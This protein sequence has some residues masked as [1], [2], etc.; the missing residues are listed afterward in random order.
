[1]S[2][3]TPGTR[4][5][6]TRTSGTRTSGSRTSG[7]QTSSRTRSRASSGRKLRAVEVEVVQVGPKPEHL[8]LGATGLLCL[9]GIVMVYSASSVASVQAS[10]ANWS[11]GV[12]QLVWM[13]LGLALGLV[14]SRIPLMFWRDRIAPV[15]IL[16]AL[17]LQAIL[18]LDIALGAVGGPHIPFAL[19]KNGATRW[20]G[21]D[22]FQVQPSDFAKLALILWLARLL[23]K[24][25]R[26]IGSRE[27]LKPIF[28]VTG[29]LSLMVLLGD[30]LGTTLLLGVIVIVMLFLA[31]A[32]LRQVGV[33]AG[34][35]ASLAALVIL[36]FGGF[37]VQRIAAY[38]NPSGHQTTGGY[39][40]LQS[41]IGFAS[42][43]LFGSGPGNSRAKWG[44]L[45]EAETDFILAIIGEELG[46]LGSLLVLGAFVVFMFAGIRIALGSRSKFGRLVAIGITTWIGVQAMINIMVT[47]GALPTKGI[48]LPFVSYGGSSL[49][50]CMLSVG[51]MVSVARDS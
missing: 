22:A 43:G 50:M 38:F 24:R 46:L 34:A 32:P 8:L 35:A 6:G 17:G 27:L 49:M 20:L 7:S 26:E 30:D 36:V 16:V 39:Q 19:T 3:R 48:T 31:G 40:L 23:D 15:M 13:V 41:Q 33:I 12:R 28:A 44:Y 42:G 51:V 1:M 10:N 11:T 47:V 25:S 2:Q 4:S 29:A 45:P 5:S 37:R 9:L 14:A 18:A 21:T